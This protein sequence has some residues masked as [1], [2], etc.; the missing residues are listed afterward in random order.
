[1]K[2]TTM[3]EICLKDMSQRLA[4]MMAMVLM[5]EAGMA[6]MMSMMMMRMA[7]IKVEAMTT[8]EEAVG[9]ARAE[10]VDAAGEAEVE[11]EKAKD[12][13]KGAE[14]AGVRA[15]EARGKATKAEA[16]AARQLSRMLISIAPSSSS[17][18]LARPLQ[19][20]GRTGTGGGRRPRRPRL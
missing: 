12:G 1:M 6:M 13:A 9:A 7:W 15:E 11:K 8:K 14:A 2:K 10:G 4:A 5:T 19:R 17:R 16:V 20:A 3:M 18:L